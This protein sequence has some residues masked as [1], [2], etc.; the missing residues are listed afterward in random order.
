ML[1][2]VVS[3]PAKKPASKP[4]TVLS[5]IQSPYT[6][7]ASH[8]PKQYT[9]PITLSGSIADEIRGVLD[10]MDITMVRYV[11]HYD[12]KRGFQ[13][14]ISNEAYTV[15]TRDLL[16][17]ILNPLEMTDVILHSI[18][19][20]QEAETLEHL[21]QTTSIARTQKTVSGIPLSV[22]TLTPR[23]SRFCY[24]YKD[25]GAHIDE[26]WLTE[27]QVAVDPATMLA[28]EL[29]L[30]KHRRIFSADQ[31]EK[32]MPTLS[33]YAYGFTYTIIGGVAVP[34]RLD[35]YIDG[36]QVLA[37]TA[38]YKKQAQYIL[39]DKREITYFLPDKSTEQ[40][41]IQYT[42]YR[43]ARPPDAIKTLPAGKYT[44]KLRRAAELSRK[45]GEALN[46]GHIQ[47]AVSILQT[48]IDSYPG[49]PQAVEAQKLLT[50]LPNGL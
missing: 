42:T 33:L 2:L 41:T 4:Y 24:R 18:L 31:Q 10:T 44:K 49:T 19:K 36:V 50:G 15:Q 13:L 11:E 43:F 21:R 25:M 20:Y 23:G 48:L 9:V 28:H 27:L 40:L 22:F 45:A 14:V 8:F 17:G 35:L 26:N 30:K 47:T 3:S 7:I 6:L 1:F 32:S 34:S 5:R 39:F 46:K 16:T 37:L 12:K 29:S 38:S